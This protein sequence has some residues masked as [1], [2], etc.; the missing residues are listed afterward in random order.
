MA[1]ST[2]PEAKRRI[3]ALLLDRAELNEVKISPGGP[4]EEEDREPEMVYFD[5]PT[6]RDPSWI[7]MGGQMDE[8]YTLTLIVE[9][10]KPGDDEIDAEERCWELIDE[11]EQALR[12]DLSLDG[13]LQGDGLNE[14]PP[15]GFGQQDVQ[16]IPHGDAWR[17]Q[18]TVPVQCHARI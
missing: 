2:A 11:I 13:L 17:A 5:G 10:T 12:A 1:A 18:A 9:L 7:V 6:V 14:T 3:L 8:D 4:T 16:T 15:L